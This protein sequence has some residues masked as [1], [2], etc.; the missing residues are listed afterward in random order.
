MVYVDHLILRE[1]SGL[2]PNFDGYGSVGEDFASIVRRKTD[3]ATRRQ[4]L[5]V[6]FPSQ[7][8]MIQSPFSFSVLGTAECALK[9]PLESRSTR[10][11]RVS[12]SSD[13]N[14]EFLEYL[15]GAICGGN[16]IEWTVAHQYNM[17][18]TLFS[19]LRDV[20]RRSLKPHSDVPGSVIA[21]GYRMDISGLERGFRRLHR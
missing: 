1:V 5:F 19:Q 12:R 20:V 15:N 2:P 11:L 7:F 17:L 4:R 16:N 6:R 18:L 3:P 10:V 14:H 8:E 9:C 13:E 21:E